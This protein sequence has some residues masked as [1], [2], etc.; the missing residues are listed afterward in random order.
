MRGSGDS[1]EDFV[2][3]GRGKVKISFDIMGGASSDHVEMEYREMLFRLET[4]RSA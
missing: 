4:E 1:S 3:V 2:I